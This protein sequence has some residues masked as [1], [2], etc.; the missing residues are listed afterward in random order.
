[1][2]HQ[3]TIDLGKRHLHVPHL[4]VTLRVIY[5]AA[6]TAADLKRNP[7]HPH[8]LNLLHPPSP[9]PSTANERRWSIIYKG[10][11]ISSI[12]LAYG[13]QV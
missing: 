7:S 6:S 5:G 11:K 3:I 4:G 13:K 9:T 12:Q 10:V 8:R 2:T 1:M